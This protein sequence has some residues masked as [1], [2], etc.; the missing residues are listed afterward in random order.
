MI[1]KLLGCCGDVGDEASL[2]LPPNLAER[3]EVFKAVGDELRLRILHLVRDQEVCVCDLQP[4]VGVVQSTLSHHLA[5][6][7]RVGLVSARKEG[8]WNY[9]KATAA[10]MEPLQI[11]ETAADQTPAATGRQRRK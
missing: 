4:L 3:A 11:F 5:V 8:R 1:E 6:L 7:Q 9:Y 2:S 10:A